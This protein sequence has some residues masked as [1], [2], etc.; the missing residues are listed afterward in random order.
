LGQKALYGANIRCKHL[1]IAG[2]NYK[3]RTEISAKLC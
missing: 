2:I 1:H 3:F